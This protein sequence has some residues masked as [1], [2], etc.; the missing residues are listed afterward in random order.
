MLQITN[1]TEVQKKCNPGCKQC[2]VTPRELH[3]MN[4]K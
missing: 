1:M 4:K 2:D 3:G